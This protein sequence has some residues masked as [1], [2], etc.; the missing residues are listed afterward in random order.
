MINQHVGRPVDQRRGR[1]E[2]KVGNH[3]NKPKK[4][5]ESLSSGADP[6]ILCQKMVKKES[7]PLGGECADKDALKP[8]ACI[9]V[10]R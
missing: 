4:D 10:A 2:K 1:G 6:V 7:S 9:D 8:P 5:G 3:A